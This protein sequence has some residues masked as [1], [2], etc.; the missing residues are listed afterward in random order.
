MG[1]DTATDVLNGFFGALAAGIADAFW[2]LAYMLMGSAIAAPAIASIALVL[3]ASNWRLIR[4]SAI[5]SVVAGAIL[6]FMSFYLSILF[7]AMIDKMALFGRAWVMV[8]PWLGGLIVLGAIYLH[9]QWRAG[10]DRARIAG[11]A[12]CVLLAV[13]AV[14]TDQL[15]R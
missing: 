15:T 12:G 10:L 2:P 14:L 11:I 13:G 8:L 6:T 3:L 4:Q 7:L 1:L 5:A 9:Y